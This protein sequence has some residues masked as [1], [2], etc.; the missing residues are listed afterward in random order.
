MIRYEEYV[1]KYQNNF[2][3]IELDTITV[4]KVKNFVSEVIKIK[5]SE[6]H[7]ITD[8]EMEEKRWT[9]GYLGECAVEKF[10]GRKFVDFSIGNSN[11]YHV[12]DLKSLGIDC[13]IKTVEKGKFPII[14]KK[15]YRPEIIVIKESEKL[16]SICGLATKEVL[17]KYQASELILSSYLKSRGTKTGFF[18]FNKLISPEKILQSK[19]IKQ[20]QEVTNG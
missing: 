2:I 14:F 17:N 16:F 19:K 10:I 5:S 7:H 13:G 4:D 1:E 11:K 6:K 3:Q 8:S 12:A 18:G 15:S 9:T 20:L